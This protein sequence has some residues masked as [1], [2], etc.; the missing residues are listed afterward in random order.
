ML[1]P[2]FVKE[3]ASSIP[4]LASQVAGKDDVAI[5][6]L[7]Q[8][9]VYS[10]ASAAW[11][12]SAHCTETVK[13]GVQTGSESGWAG[14]LTGCVGTTVNESREMYWIR[15]MQALGAPVS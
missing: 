13:Q 14:F 7:V 6:A 1:M 11:F 2:P 9:D 3:Y 10:F 5:L 12:Y 8:P 15:A 4:E